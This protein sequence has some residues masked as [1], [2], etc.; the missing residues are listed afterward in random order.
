MQAEKMLTE[1]PPEGMMLGLRAAEKKPSEV[2][3]QQT[4]RGV[5]SAAED[6]VKEWAL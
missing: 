6:V 5:Q 2:G 3:G 4:G 1:G